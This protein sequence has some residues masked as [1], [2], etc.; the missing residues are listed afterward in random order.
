M[1]EVWKEIQDYPTF[2]VSTWGRVRRTKT[3]RILKEYRNKKRKGGGYSTVSIYNGHGTGKYQMKYFYVHKLVMMTFSSENPFCAHCGMKKEVNHK[4]G[5]RHNNRLDN[6]EYVT[7]QENID[8]YAPM[9]QEKR[10]QWLNSKSSYID[11]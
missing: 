8:R 7:Q 9:W 3:K 6:L 10:E 4:D 11:K 2:E 1:E 5:N